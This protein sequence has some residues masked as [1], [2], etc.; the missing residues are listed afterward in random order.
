MHFKIIE[1]IWNLPKFSRL[2]QTNLEKES[3]EIE[4]RVLV[5]EDYHSAEPSQY[6]S[7]LPLVLNKLKVK[8][9]ILHDLTQLAN[10]THI[11]HEQ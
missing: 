2:S 5:L 9:T 3:D 7:H 11:L 6:Q 1:T 10:M 4:E 8:A